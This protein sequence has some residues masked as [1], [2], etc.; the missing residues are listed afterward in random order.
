MSIAEKLETIAENEQKVFDAGKKSQYDEF[1]D[2]FQN[3]GA[4]LNGNHMFSGVAW[5]PENFKPKYDILV[6]RADYIFMETRR[7]KCS[8]IDVFNEQGIVLDTS[9][10][11]T[12]SNAFAFSAITEIP[13]LDTTN[14]TAAGALD[15]TFGQC[16]QLR[17]IVKITIKA[18]YRCTSL[19]LNCYALEEVDFS[20]TLGASLNMSYCS[21]LNKPSITSLINILSTATT[22]LTVTLSLTAVKKAFETSIGANDGNTSAEWTSLIATKS[23][24]T[25]SLV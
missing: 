5:T 24:F 4:V 20:G 23:N 17:K 19:F 25:I 13:E 12:L 3:Y 6:N 22:G 15:A 21:K 7:L 1:W 18:V 11:T 8:L 16:Q 9:R 10:A 2:A 14:C